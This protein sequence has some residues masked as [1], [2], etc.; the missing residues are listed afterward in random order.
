MYC[1]GRLPRGRTERAHTHSND[2]LSF[3][4]ALKRQI[5]LNFI[6]IP[7][8]SIHTVDF[9]CCVAQQNCCVSP[10]VSHVSSL[11]FCSLVCFLSL[12]LSLSLILFYAISRLFASF[13]FLLYD[14]ISDIANAISNGIY[15]ICIVCAPF[16]PFLLVCCCWCCFFYFFLS[17]LVS[18][19]RLASSI[20]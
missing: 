8:I 13:T 5:S 20:S 17:S 12:S 2:A 7:F 16:I 10:C 1:T 18:H 14:L 15:F 9:Y 19:L 11:L 4:K 6:V 3:T